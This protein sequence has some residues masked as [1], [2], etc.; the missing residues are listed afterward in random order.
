MCS[1]YIYKVVNNVEI[2]FIVSVA[3]TAYHATEMYEQYSQ[4]Y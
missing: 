1:R 4:L 3:E 2:M